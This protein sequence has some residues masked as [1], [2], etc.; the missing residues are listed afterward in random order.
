[1]FIGGVDTLATIKLQKHIKRKHDE[2]A[3][4]NKYKLNSDNASK[5]NLETSQVNETDS[6]DQESDDSVHNISD[7]EFS[8]TDAVA[9]SQMRIPL[10][11][12]VKEADKYGISDRATA[13]LATAVLIDFGIVTKA[14]RSLVVDNNKVHRERMKFRKSLQKGRSHSTENITSIYFE[15]RRDKTRIKIKRQDKWYGD[16]TVEDHY[17]LVT[18]PG[19]Y[20]LT[21][22][23]HTTHWKK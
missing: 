2:Q 21:H 23:H 4:V 13:S 6:D 11:N 3:R 20:Y 17:V 8:T 22:S 7:D 16:S 5:L 9:K 10:P 1:M 12:L 15:G 19:G 18:K 14:D